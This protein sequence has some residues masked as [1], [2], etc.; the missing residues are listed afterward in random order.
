M[1]AI[2]EELKKNTATPYFDDL[3]SSDQ[4]EKR[5][6]EYEAAAQQ[7]KVE[8]EQQQQIQ[9]TNEK[10]T[11]SQQKLDE[12]MNR[13]L[14]SP[15]F[16]QALVEEPLRLSRN[17]A[18]AKGFSVIGDMINLGARAKVNRRQPDNMEA[19]YMNDFYRQL[20]RYGA[21]V[22]DW[23]ARNSAR[24]DRIGM[25]GIQNARIEEDNARRDEAIKYQKGQDDKTWKW[26]EGEIEREIDRAKQIGDINKAN[27][28]E[29][30][31]KEH[32]NRMKEYGI[33]YDG[34]GRSSGSSGSSGSD[35]IIIQTKNGYVPMNKA[36]YSYYR[37]LAMKNAQELSVYD[38]SLFDKI[39]VVDKYDQPIPGEFEYVLRKGVD[40][41]DLVR[42][43][44][45]LEDE[46][47]KQQT[48]PASGQKLPPY[49]YPGAPLRPGEKL[50]E[51]SQFGK[52]ETQQ[53]AQ[54]NKTKTPS[55]FQ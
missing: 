11:L 51:Q 5:Q 8:Q 32:E 15:Y 42:A 54:E 3:Q 37:G 39:P 22:N 10:R 20:E 4:I 18:I 27:Q 53:P 16:D 49:D 45:E 26:R 24:Q 30:M 13:E 7:A 55:F 17:N 35:E 47:K 31:K 29:L 2:T 52:Y 43:F 50:P 14:P 41:D 6:A 38:N 46:K 21:N 40:E 12:L 28:L 36:N 19:K 44:I 34:N 1:S 33:R 9:A 23:N 25:E 48:A